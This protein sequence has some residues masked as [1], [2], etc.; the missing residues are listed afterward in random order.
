MSEAAGFLCTGMTACYAL[1]YLAAPTKMPYVDKA[2]IR[3]TNAFYADGDSKQ[4]DDTLHGVKVPP[5]CVLIHSA[6]GGVG[7]ML[8]QMCKRV[9][10]FTCVIGVVGGQHK[11]EMAEQMGC[12]VVIDRKSKHLKDGNIWDEMKRRIP[13]LNGLDVVFDANGVTTLKQSYE[14][15]KATGRVIVYGFHT[16]L[17]HSGWIN[18]FQWIQMGYNLFKTPKFNPMELV[19]E[20]KAVLGFNLSFLFSRTDILKIAMASLL[21]WIESGQV[22]VS[23][24][25]EYKMKDVGKA[26]KDI[27]SGN[28]IGKLVMITPHHVDYDKR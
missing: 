19:N 17:P 8:A 21:E 5:Q 10:G 14:N 12:D 13:D 2:V 25:T 24:V 15:L 7:S 27:Q 3:H 23:K 4:N 18:P 26:H 20:N 16:M 11:V 9:A 6:S 1:F 22:K 28:T